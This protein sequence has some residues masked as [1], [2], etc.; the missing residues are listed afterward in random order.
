[1]V[2][3][4]RALALLLLVVA[5][6]STGAV[7]VWQPRAAK[8]E[9]VAAS[10]LGVIYAA[11]AERVETHVLRS[12]ETLS[13]IL[14]RASIT[15]NELAELLFELRRHENPRRLSIG[16][17]VTVRRW[18]ATNNP[19]AVEVRLN[20]DS[21]LRLARAAYGWGGEMVITPTALD[22]V[23]VSGVIERGQT[24]YEAMIMDERSRVRPSE[25]LPLVLALADLF[26]FKLDF[27]R[28]IQPDDRYRMVYERE[29]RP[30]GTVRRHRILAAELVNSGKTYTGYWYDDG[31]DI[32]GYYDAEGASLRA[33]FLRYPVEFRRI[34]SPFNPR[35][36]HPVLGTYRAHNGTDFGAP[37]GTPVRVVADGTVVFA[38]VNGGYGNVVD[39]RHANGYL[40]RYAHL[41][42][43][44]SGVRAGTKVSQ[45][46]V[47]GYVGATGLATG[48][49]LHYELHQNG[50][51]VDPSRAPREGPKLAAGHLT[52]FRQVA[53]ERSS[54]LETYEFRTT[55]YARRPSSSSATVELD[56]S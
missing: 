25:R 51:A 16:S 38:G 47:I 14:A 48:P 13:G 19:R 17:E 56:G 1:M 2:N 9:A 53:A 7:A 15:G 20:P 18:A 11:P 35:R 30:D 43:F 37:T 36:F 50:R 22:T 5:G 3:P 55:R 23:Y 33:G 28:E 39:V 31:N 10:T 21:T 4:K 44:G 49:H 45:E 29:A 34:T 27:T 46:Q 12:G 41:S 54:L 8:G 26:Q 40:T 42:R 32:R 6:G 52:A 24:L